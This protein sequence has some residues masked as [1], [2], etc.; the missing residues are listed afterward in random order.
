M[1]DF[2]ILGGDDGAAVIDLDMGGDRPAFDLDAVTTMDDTSRSGIGIDLLKKSTIQGQSGGF[3][4]P[5]VEVDMKD[6]RDIGSGGGGTESGGG[7]G[8][9]SRMFSG[10]GGG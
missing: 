5:P 7:A 3:A 2:Q 4:P 10:F 1:E 6:M 9:F 8:F